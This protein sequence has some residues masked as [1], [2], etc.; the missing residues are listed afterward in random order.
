MSWNSLPHSLTKER[1]NFLTLQVCHLFHSH[2][3]GWVSNWKKA[4]GG[5]IQVCRGCCGT[6]KTSDGLTLSLLKQSS[7]GELVTP[8]R[9]SVCHWLSAFRLLSPA[10]ICSSLHIPQDVRSRLTTVHLCDLRQVF[11]LS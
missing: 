3:G 8:K 2:A 6:L 9:E 7:S 4:L 10:S 11:N 1:N 5:N